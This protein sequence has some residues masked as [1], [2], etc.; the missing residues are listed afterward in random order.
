MKNN[1]MS[2]FST[3]FITLVNFPANGMYL[4]NETNDSTCDIRKVR[5][6]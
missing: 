2:V 4:Y 6:T 3:I 1:T 5:K